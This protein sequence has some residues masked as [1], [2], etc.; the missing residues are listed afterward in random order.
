MMVGFP[1]RSINTKTHIDDGFKD[2]RKKSLHGLE[3]RDGDVCMNI[4]YLYSRECEE[5][6]CCC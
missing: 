6:R 4:L 1:Q 5:G 3:R 2:G